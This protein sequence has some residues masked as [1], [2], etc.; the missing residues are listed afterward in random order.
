MHSKLFT[1]FFIISL[2]V[3]SVN[4]KISFKKNISNPFIFSNQNSMMILGLGLIISITTVLTLYKK[5]QLNCRK[6]QEKTWEKCIK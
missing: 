6:M 3:A 4:C 1:L 5:E 2:F